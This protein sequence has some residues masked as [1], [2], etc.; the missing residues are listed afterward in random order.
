MLFAA[1]LINTAH[2]TLKYAVETL[3]GISGNHK[4][5]LAI[6]VSILAAMMVNG[7]MAGELAF[8][9]SVLVRFV[10]HNARLFR[11]VFANDGQNVSLAGALDVERTNVAATLDQRENCVL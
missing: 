4:A 5:A 1:V 2:S 11:D 3:G 9:A 7:V 10:G 6:L 8:K